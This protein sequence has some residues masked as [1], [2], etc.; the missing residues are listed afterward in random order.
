MGFYSSWGLRFF[1]LC[2]TLVTT[3]EKVG[4]ILFSLFSNWK[5]N[6]FGFCES[7]VVI[8]YNTRNYFHCRSESVGKIYAQNKFIQHLIGF[9]WFNFFSEECFI[10]LY[11][12]LAQIK[13]WLH[14]TP[15]IIQCPYQL[16]R[17]MYTNLSKTFWYRR[18]RKK[19]HVTTANVLRV[20][21]SPWFLDLRISGKSEKASLWGR[22]HRD[23]LL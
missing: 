9:V 15:C 7:V 8:V 1:F 20:G 5:H 3:S 13:K 11:N 12:S 22:S 4:P 19:A 18:Q 16:L 2:P 23:L 14:C 6:F 10:P 17:E 21:I